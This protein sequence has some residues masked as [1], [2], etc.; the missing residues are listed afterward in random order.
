MSLKDFQKKIGALPDNVFG[1]ETLSKAMI[2][3]DLS[4]EQT[5]HFF[6]QIAHETGNFS[7][8]SENLNYS[9]KGLLNTFSKYFDS[10]SAIKYQKNPEKIASKVYANRMGNS[11]EESKEGWK[12][13]GR[14]AIQLTGKSN[15]IAFSNYIKNPLILENPELILSDYCFESALFFFTRNNIWKLCNKVDDISIINVTKKING[16]VNGLAHRKE[17]TKKYYQLLN[18]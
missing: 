10:T 17:L 14:G 4:K 8:F 12:Y 7:L 15:Y 3:Y 6:G 5:A 18:S 13:R 1:K 16:G 11:N 9:T 2:F